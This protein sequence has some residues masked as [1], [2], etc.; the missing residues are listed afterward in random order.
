M[1][2]YW[3]PGV[4]E[5]LKTNRTVMQSGGDVLGSRFRDDELPRVLPS[6]TR[7]SEMMYR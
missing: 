4:I 6:V 1:E 2:E 7:Y 3:L 5:F